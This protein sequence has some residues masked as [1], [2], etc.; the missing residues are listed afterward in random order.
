[1]TCQVLPRTST[2]TGATAPTR[3]SRPRAE[4]G[5][6]PT[7]RARGGSCA[8][9]APPARRSR[10]GCPPGSHYQRRSGQV[11]RLGARQPRLQGA[12][13]GSTVQSLPQRGQAPRPGRLL[14]LGPGLRATP[15]GFIAPALTCSAYNP[16][17][18][19]NENVAEFCDPA[20]DREI[21]R[22]QSLQ[23]SDPGGGVPPVGQD[24]PRHHRAGALGPVRERRRARG[25]LDA[26]RQ[27]PVQPAV[28]HAARP[29]LGP[30]SAGADTSARDELGLPSR[31]K[32]SRDK[33][34]AIYISADAGDIWLIKRWLR[35]G[36]PAAEAIATTEVNDCTPTC[37]GGHRTSATTTILFSRRVARGGVPAYAGFEVMKSS[38]ESVAAV[39]DERDLEGL[40][41]PS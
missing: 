1:M 6:R 40:C 35:Y 19:Q 7:W 41:P 3:P 13:P 21:A 24:R 29:A 27:L 22:A 37:A 14:R 10:S 11:R 34:S 4:P 16:V 25:R 32:A 5:R 28:G 30:L 17:T 36:R 23:T 31:A 9:R 8:P 15:A 33:P 12:L 38:D 39:G 20:I 18:S 26:G 2:A